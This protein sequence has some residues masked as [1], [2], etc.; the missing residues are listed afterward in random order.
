MRAVELL[1]AAGLLGALVFTGGAVGGAERAATGA[2]EASAVDVR[3]L[4]AKG[5]G[6]ADD[7]A[8]FLAAISRAH[9]GDGV[10]L[11]PRGRYRISRPLRLDKVALNGSGVRAWPADVDALPALIPTHRDGPAIILGAGG[12]LSGLGITYHWD[13]EPD[14]GPPA[15]LIS[16]IGATIRDLRI[17]YAWDGILT[18]GEHNVGRVNIANVF[19]VSI[20]NVGIRITGTWDVPRLCNI[21]VWNA[22]PVP[23]GLRAGTGFLLGKNDLV[24]MTDCF[25]FGMHWGFRFEDRIEGCK[26]EGGTWG[27]LNGC[28]TDFCAIGMSVKGGHTVSV[29]GGS[30]WNHQESLVVEGGDARVRVT[31]SELKSNGAPVVRVRSCDHA[32]LTG[33]S[34]LRPMKT[35]DAP[36][37]LLEGGRVVLGT[38]H[39]ES[40]GPGVVIESG[41]RSAA[42]TGNMI[43]S[44]GH[45]AVVDRRG[46]QSTIVIESNAVTLSSKKTADE[47]AP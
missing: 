21:E 9:S 20:R 33:C 12:A 22:G 30:F 39:I 43:D 7:T 8:A 26:I 6:K 2:V 19:M 46:P 32:V 11:V 31:G 45:A 40:Y 15:V 10:V 27:V 18:D 35:F 24:R 4:G 36:A 1:P 44:H 5:D 42:V 29:S 17:R 16:G 34:L 28:A 47:E 41:V 38:N 3:A 14:E 23:R 13:E 37:V 25:A